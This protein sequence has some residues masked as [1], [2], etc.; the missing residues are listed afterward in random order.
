MSRRMRRARGFIA[1][2]T[3]AADVSPGLTKSLLLKA[4]DNEVLSVIELVVNALAGNIEFN[5]ASRLE[6]L[7]SKCILKR[8]ALQ[9][10]PS[11]AREI[12]LRHYKTV[13]K[14]LRLCAPFLTDILQRKTRFGNHRLDSLQS[15][16]Y[17]DV[18]TPG[19]HSDDAE[20]SSRRH[21][22]DVEKS[23]KRYCNDNA[24]TSRRRSTD[25]ETTPKRRAYVQE[26]V[27][28]RRSNV[29]S[30]SSDSSSSSK[31]SKSSSS[32]SSSSSSRSRSSRSRSS[33]S[34]SSR[35]LSSSTSSSRSSSSSSSSS[36]RSSSYTRYSSSSFSL[37]DSLT[38]LD[39][40][41]ESLKDGGCIN[42]KKKSFT[43]VSEGIPLVS[44]EGIESE[45]LPAV[46]VT[47]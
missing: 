45:E 41:S 23:S 27:G 34:R 13:I 15:Q 7:K 16:S 42:L 3:S 28:G 30:S 38:S 35:S 1:L 43:T 2:V 32:S 37:S 20:R 44:L 29:R 31:T 4:K 26:T 46:N 12:I 24:A 36:S 17:D 40:E 39:S 22:D 9:N 14:L 5:D 19:H 18:P 21:S 11:Q 8:L 6:L 25:S 33:R 47:T 10:S